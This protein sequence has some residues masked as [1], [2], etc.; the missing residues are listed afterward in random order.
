MIVRA[1]VRLIDCVICLAIVPGCGL[2]QQ[3]DRLGAPFMR[4]R[5]SEGHLVADIVRS[6]S[7]CFAA[8]GLARPV[9]QLLLLLGEVFGGVPRKT[10]AFVGCVCAER[11]NRFVLFGSPW[12]CAVRRVLKRTKRSPRRCKRAV[13]PHTIACRAAG[14][15]HRSSARSRRRSSRPI[16]VGTGGWA[17]ATSCASFVSRAR[18]LFKSGAGAR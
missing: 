7:E 4:Q 17:L 8:G 14:W 6:C 10:A 11:P 5:L 18:K 16:P 12:S 9:T 3:R 1:I 15:R 13:R 2:A